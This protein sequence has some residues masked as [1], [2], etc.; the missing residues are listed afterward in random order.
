MTFQFIAQCLNN[1]ATSCLCPLDHMRWKLFKKTM[2][3]SVKQLDTDSSGILTRAF[4]VFP[5][6]PWKMPSVKQ[7]PV[8]FGSLYMTATPVGAA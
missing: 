6:S 7:H 1:C 5:Q 4:Y 8:P 3:C 2:L